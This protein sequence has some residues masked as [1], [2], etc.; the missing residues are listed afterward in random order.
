MHD[1]KSM[2]FIREREMGSQI[3]NISSNG[4]HFVNH[5]IKQRL[6]NHKGGLNGF[7]LAIQMNFNLI[8]HGLKIGGWLEFLIFFKSLKFWVAFEV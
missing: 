7:K 4:L 6:N 8:E 5:G 1:T 2:R 3:G